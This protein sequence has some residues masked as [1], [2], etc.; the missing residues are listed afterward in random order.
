MFDEAAEEFKIYPNVMVI[1][2]KDTLSY[3]EPVIK[4]LTSIEMSTPKY[5][6]EYVNMFTAAST[7]LEACGINLTMYDD[8]NFSHID[9]SV[10]NYEPEKKYYADITAKMLGKIEQELT[11]KNE[12]SRKE[13]IDSRRFVYSSES[14]ISFIQYMFRNDMLDCNFV[15]RSSNTKDTLKYDL[16]FLYYLTSRVCNMLQIHKKRVRLR[17]NFG[18]AH[19]II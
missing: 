10:L 3:V 4:E 15:I 11:G 13:N 19:I 18:S 16:Q 17:V 9:N 1:R 2:H 5:V 6:A 8:G 14:C 12:Y 7:N